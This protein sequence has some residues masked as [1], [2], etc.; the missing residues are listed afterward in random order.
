[1][2]F[3]MQQVLKEYHLL[4]QSPV[5]NFASYILRALSVSAGCPEKACYSCTPV[6]CSSSV[7]SLVLKQ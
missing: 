4:H 7:F 6:L 1:M 2:C 5:Q 3:S